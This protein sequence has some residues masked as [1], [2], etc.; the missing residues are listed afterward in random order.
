MQAVVIRTVWPSGLRRWLQAPVR[1][2]VGSNPTAV[3]LRSCTPGPLLSLVASHQE[4]DMLRVDRHTERVSSKVG[5]FRSW[6]LLNA[7]LRKTT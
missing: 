4:H 1:K 5:G 3:I 7:D 2:G 6:L